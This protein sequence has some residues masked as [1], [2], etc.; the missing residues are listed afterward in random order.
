MAQTDTFTRAVPILVYE[1]LALTTLSPG[2]AG[3]VKLTVPPELPCVAELVGL[4]EVIGRA[5]GVVAAGDLV[6]AG[7]VAAAEV[8]DVEGDADAG[9][10]LVAVA[11]A[12][13]EPSEAGP[14]AAVEAVDPVPPHAV[15]PA[16]PMTTAAMI[17]IGIRRI[18]MLSPF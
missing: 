16:P 2:M 15:S 12:A 6:A 17:T 1:P 11:T 14:D 3:T 5:G 18:L 13:A 10:E 4:A 9:D 7:C 8:A